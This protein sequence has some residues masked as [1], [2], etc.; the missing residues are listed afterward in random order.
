MAR[1]VP[2]PSQFNRR[3]EAG[4]SVNIRVYQILSRP[5]FGG[6]RIEFGDGWD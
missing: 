5:E 6:T 4:D 3:E 2:D 1:T